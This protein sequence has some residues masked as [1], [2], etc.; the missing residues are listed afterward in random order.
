MGNLTRTYLFFSGGQSHRLVD[1]GGVAI[2]G[3]GIGPHTFSTAESRV[4]PETI[5]G[6]ECPVCFKQALASSSTTPIREK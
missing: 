6:V 4:D 1:A 3:V 2:C 5:A